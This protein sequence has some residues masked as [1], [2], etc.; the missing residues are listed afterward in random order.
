MEKVIILPVYNSYT[1]GQAE[2]KKYDFSFAYK[3]KD[4][5]YYKGKVITYPDNPHILEI[6]YNEIFIKLTGDSESLNMTYLD[7]KFIA[8][9]SLEYK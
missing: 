6:P 8:F 4:K 2:I 7:D 3:A 1:Q 5:V 9:N